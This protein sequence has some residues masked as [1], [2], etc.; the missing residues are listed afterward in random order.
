MYKWWNFVENIGIIPET[1]NFSCKIVQYLKIW[2]KN[3]KNYVFCEEK[4]KSNVADDDEICLEQN[5][6]A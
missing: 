4:K 3:S 2:G 5:N 1:K 6:F